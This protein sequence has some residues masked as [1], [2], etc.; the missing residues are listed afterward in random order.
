MRINVEDALK[1]ADTKKRDT[2]DV[3]ARYQ[4]ALFNLKLVRHDG[5]HGVHNRD[6]VA[7]IL[8]SVRDDFKS[9]QDDLDKSW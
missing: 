8:K 3:W 5:T 6:Y 4:K 7:E 2:K 1:E 9:I